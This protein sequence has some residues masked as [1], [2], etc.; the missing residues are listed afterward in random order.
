MGYP[1]VKKYA[2]VYN[3]QKLFSDQTMRVLDT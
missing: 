2:E 3:A 1:E